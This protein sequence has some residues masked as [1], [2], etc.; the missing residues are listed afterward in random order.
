[1]T[2]SDIILFSAVAVL[3]CNHAV[4]RLPGWLDRMWLFWGVQLLNLSASCYLLGFGIPEFRANL[5]V[6]N[7][8]FGLLFIFHIVSNNRRLQRERADRQR[9]SGSEQTAHQEQIR[10]ALR[11]GEE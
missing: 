7:W 3:A 5:A 6:A 4:L 2:Q 9:R 1:M 11:A 10:A 8:M